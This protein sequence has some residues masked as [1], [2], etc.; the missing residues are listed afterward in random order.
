MTLWPDG[1]RKPLD[2]VGTHS[3]CELKGTSISIHWE[4]HGVQSHLSERCTPDL[5]HLVYLG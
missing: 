3:R 4:S 1:R 5:R 2:T